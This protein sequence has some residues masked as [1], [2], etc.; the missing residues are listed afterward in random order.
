MS[1]VIIVGGG[2]VGVAMAMNCARYGFDVT[3]LEKEHQI[4]PL[5]RAIVMDDEV[6][7]ALTLSGADGLGSV[8]SPLAG[9]EFID[10][11]GTR[12][13]GIDVPDG[14]L[15]GSGFPPVVRY[16]QPELEQFLRES[17]LRLG[18]GLRLGEEVSSVTQTESGVDVILVSGDTIRGDWLI[19]A[20]GAA[21]PIRKQLGIAFESLGFDQSWLVVDVRV[22]ENF[23]PELPTHVQQICDPVRPATFVPGHNRF[24]RWEFQL[25]AD[26]S[27]EEMVAEENVWTLLAPW[28]APTE[29][30]IIRAVVYRFHATVAERMRSNRIF[31]A[32]DAAHQMP[33][34]LGQGLCTGIRDAA[35]LPWKL[36]L[37][38]KGLAGEALL[39]TYDG[40]RRPHAT[41]VV[42][43]AA[44]MGKLIDHLSRP[45]Q[46]GNDLSDAYGGQRPFPKLETGFLSGTH[47]AVGTQASDITLADGDRFDAKIGK[48][49]AVVIPQDLSADDEF[50][51]PWKQ[52]DAAIVTGTIPFVDGI[53]VVR[54]DRCIASVSSTEDEFRM[55]T[56]EL[57]EMLR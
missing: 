13:I 44:D 56:T 36:H 2:P 20:D 6:Q 27:R 35:N 24:R 37:F 30:E 33:P 39:D 34:F 25:H 38:E 43:H 9:A 54:P 15:M 50:L 1:S 5:P 22:R 23:A 8:T 7:R 31:I 57:M 32:G 21:S 45:S 47:P 12:I 52:L 55:S 17:A 51:E 14:L 53:V 16:Y 19:A 42:A 26:E 28:I 40:E 48:N 29:A 3:V 10:G 41:R 46:D 18:V 4:H 49:F 11:S